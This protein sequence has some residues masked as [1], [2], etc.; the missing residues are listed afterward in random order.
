[1]ATYITLDQLIDANACK[2]QREEFSRLFPSGKARVTVERAKALALVFDWDWAAR[3][4]LTPEGEAAYWAATAPAWAT[5]EAVRAT[6]LAAYDDARADAWAT[7]NAVRATALAAY[8]DA[9]A[10]ARAAYNAAKAEAFARIY[11]DQ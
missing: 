2:S 9:R 10:D 4:L 5:Y 3:R 6:A 11:L 1:M 8:D 7:Y